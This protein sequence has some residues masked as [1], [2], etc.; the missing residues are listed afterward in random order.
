MLQQSRCWWWRQSFIE[1]RT[2][3]NDGNEE[4]VEVKAEEVFEEEQVPW[5]N[6]R[7]PGHHP[8]SPWRIKLNHTGVVEKPVHFLAGVAIIFRSEWKR[9]LWRPP[10]R[11]TRHNLD[12]RLNVENSKASANKSPVQGNWRQ[13]YFPY[14]D[15]SGSEEHRVDEG[16]CA[17]VYKT[18]NLVANACATR[19][20]CCQNLHAPSESWKL[21]WI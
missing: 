19:I 13:I 17:E 16:Y 3:L 14:V 12:G 2:I 15:A 20:F 21:Y 5:F 18:G 10:K 8:W 6:T 7:A 9:L 4:E 11:G 1:E